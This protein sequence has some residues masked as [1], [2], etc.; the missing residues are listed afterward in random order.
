V[1][2]LVAPLIV[3]ALLG[4][5]GCGGGDE[6]TPPAHRAAPKAP[7]MLDFESMPTVGDEVSTVSNAG[8][9]DVKVEVRSTGGASVEAVEGPDGGHAVRFPAYSG[10]AAAPAAVLV[11]TEQ[12]GH[13]LDPG[14]DGF[15]FGAS[16]QLDEKSSGSEADNGDNLVQRGT[17]DSPGQLKIQLDH[18]VPS[19][20]VKGDAGEAFVKADGPVDPGAWY[21]VTCERKG[22]DLELTVK[23]YD[24]GTGG[25]S[26]HTSAPTGNI[27]MDD[28]P[29]TIG[30]KTGPDGTPVASPDQFN[31]AVD[32]IFFRVG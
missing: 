13:A 9:A 30:G 6:D 27:T 25:G 17:F 15:T 2:R 4:L 8:S 11:A 3:L 20:R 24:D 12:S 29:L 5:S 22:S 10:A 31:G 16:F 23:A 1:V 18:D 32:D 28:L 7:F 21:S 26:W 19:C 14:A